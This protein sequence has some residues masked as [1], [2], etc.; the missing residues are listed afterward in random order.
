MHPAYAKAK[1]LKRKRVRGNLN[2]SDR[3]TRAVLG[4]QGLEGK[5]LE[6]AL[7]EIGLYPTCGTCG[8]EKDWKRKLK[9]WAELHDIQ[10]VAKAGSRSTRATRTRQPVQQQQQQSLELGGIVTVGLGF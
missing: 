1:E 2:F 10:L 7:K 4:K 8:K 3:L 6:L 5:Q 9:L